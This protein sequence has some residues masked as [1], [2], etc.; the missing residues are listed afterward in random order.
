MHFADFGWADHDSPPL[1]EAPLSVIQSLTDAVVT[2][3]DGEISFPDLPWRIAVDPIQMPHPQGYVLQIQPDGISVVGHDPA[4]IFYGMMTLQ[5]LARQAQGLSALPCLQVTDYPEFANRGIMLDV[6]R[7][8]V[9]TMESLY[10]IVDRMAEWKQNQLQLYTE[11]TFAYEGHEVVWEN[12][13]PMTPEQIRAL[14]SY[15]QERFIELVPNQN[16]F[17]HMHRWLAHDAYADLA[18][19][20]GSPDLSPV[21]P[22]SID[23]LADMYSKLLPNFS[24]EWVN[25]GC[26]ETFS[27]GKGQSKAAAEAQGVGR[28][29]LDF[30]LQIDALTRQH[31]KRMQFWGDIILGHPE[32]IPELPKDITAMA[33]GYEANHPFASQGQRFAEAGIDFYVCPGTSSWNSLV[34][35]TDNALGNLRNA[36]VN[37]RDNGAVGYLITDWGDNGH[38]QFPP[39]SYPGFLYGAS[40]SWA[41][42]ANVD[43]DLARALDVHVFEDQAGRTGRLVLDLG[44]AYQQTGVLVGNNTA[45][46]GL[47]LSGVEQPLNATWLRSVTAQ[48]MEATLRYVD[49]VMADLETAE[50]T[51]DDAE[52]IRHELELGADMVRFACRLGR[53]RAEANGVATSHLPRTVRTELAQELSALIPRFEKLWL[54]RNRPGGLQDSIGRFR[55][56]LEILEA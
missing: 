27:L 5:Q 1:S 44:N 45:F 54:E 21:N 33:W 36:A 25:V 42:D 32:L 56:L 41:V 46:Y 20:P 22:G 29:Y 18:E 9:P 40:V 26:D 24:S 7:D 10:A 51:G 50:L 16:S 3:E 4:G 47:L 11:H 31:G 55:N 12:A 19:Y 23:L 30:L 17:G 2:E 52:L 13:S 34:G 35:R 48:S 53:A 6:A 37:G 14:D 28:V 43:L 49:R 39:V 8:K 38:W 15:C